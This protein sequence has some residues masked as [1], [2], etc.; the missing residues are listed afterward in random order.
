[1]DL[2]T[3]SRR[4]TLRQP[5]LS[6]TTEDD[7]ADG[8]PRRLITATAGGHIEVRD[9]TNG[10]VVAAQDVPVPEGWSQRA[11]TV[12]PA[13]D[14]ILVGGEGGV[15]AYALADLRERWRNTLDLSARWVQ[16]DCGGEICVFSYRGG[17]QVLDPATGRTR[18]TGDHWTAAAQAGPYLL[19]T[20]NEGVDGNYPLAVLDPDTGTVLG[21]FGA[22]QVTGDARPDGTLVGQHQRVGDE[23]LWYALLDPA[24]RGVRV[25]GM[26]T[27]VADDCRSTTAVLVCRG[28][29][30]SVAIW[31]L[32]AS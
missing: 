16:S 32:T 2:A 15:T 12:W 31:P 28:I 4:W 22:W 20:G 19:F 27:G 5:P 17:V 13:G 14:L 8:F 7:W 9:T 24:T 11:I 30:A 18:W 29:D 10:V 25:L 3:G 23:T 21:D 6:Y 1:M 26:A